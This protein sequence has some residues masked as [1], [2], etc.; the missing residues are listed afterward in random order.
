[1]TKKNAEKNS[2]NILGPK[3]EPKFFLERWKLGFLS[4]LF[5]PKDQSKKPKNQADLIKMRE[6]EL[7]HLSEFY[8]KKRHDGEISTTCPLEAH[9]EGETQRKDDPLQ[10]DEKHLD[11]E[12]HNGAGNVEWFIDSKL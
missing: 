6:N 1:M 10:K 5:K 7:I 2:P 8:N 3:P 4:R 9:H 12:L 11:E